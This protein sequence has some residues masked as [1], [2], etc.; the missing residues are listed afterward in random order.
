MRTIFIAGLAAALQFAT[1]SHAVTNLGFETGN[2][3]GWT[4]NG[5]AGATTAIG[6]FTPATGNWFGY[7]QSAQQGVYQT[8][9]QVVTLGAGQV[10]KG[11]V[12][13]ST[14]DYMPYNDNGYFRI[15]G[16]NIFAAS[17]SSVGNYGSTGWL[18]WSFTA[19]AA[20]NYTLR[21]GVR[22]QGD[23]AAPSYAVLDAG[24]VP[25]PGTWVMMIA[26]FALVG[27]GARGRDSRM[28]RVTN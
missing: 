6:G 3:S 17:V 10:L 24:V 28:S 8:L 15:N 13:F 1:P 20:G 4:V 22:N 12:G 16:Q 21:L 26:G 19:P 2:T 25:E 14:T 9:T 5:A 11:K 23:S 7:V 27:L 18:D